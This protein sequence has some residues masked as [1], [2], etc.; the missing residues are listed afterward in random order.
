[1]IYVNPC[2]IPITFLIKNA[3]NYATSH[4]KKRPWEVKT[5][6]HSINSNEVSYFYFIVVPNKWKGMG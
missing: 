5:I 3:T 2:E 4:Q 1:M 6:T